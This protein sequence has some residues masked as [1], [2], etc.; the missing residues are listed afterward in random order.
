VDKATRDYL[1]GHVDDSA[2]AVYVHDV[3]VEAMAKAIEKIVFDL[4]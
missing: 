1:T 2:D 4:D 3:S